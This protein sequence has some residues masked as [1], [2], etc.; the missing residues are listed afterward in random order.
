MNTPRTCA[1]LLCA[2]TAS[3]ASGCGALTSKGEQGA[4][5]FFSLE[6]AQ[7]SGVVRAEALTARKGRAKLRIG[8]V[9]GARH[10][11][12]RLVFRT[13]A[14]EIG[15][16]RER[17]WTEPPELCLKRL[18]ARVLFEELGLQQVVGG[19][20]V[21]LD[22]QLTAFDEIRSP[23]HLART[24]VVVRLH[25]EHLVLWEETLTVDRLV[26]A[27]KDS[28]LAVATV[29]ALSEAMEAVV[30]R[31]ASHVVCELDPNRQGARSGCGRGHQVP[32]STVPVQGSIP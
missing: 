27:G 4:A 10:L 32:K 22:V 21:T 29:E 23:H 20:G 9:T 12:E 28:D 18:L 3:S 19:A 15:Y 25:D 30:D 11:E 5:R 31:I 17:R 13:S 2:I 1:L 16:Y 6:R 8:R 26:V 14:Y 24:Q 7:R